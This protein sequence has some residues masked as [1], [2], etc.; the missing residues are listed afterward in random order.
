[1]GDLHRAGGVPAVMKELGD[2][3]DTSVL[4]VSG[5]TLGDTIAGVEVVD[6]LVIR[7]ISDP[8]HKK[9]GIAVLRGSL[10]PDSCVAKVSA[11]SPKMMMFEGRA[12][13]FEREED[14]VDAIHRGVVGPG[15]AVIIRYEG[16]K[17]GPG[18]REMLTATSAIVGHGLEESVALIT[19]GRFSGATRGPCIG[20]ISPEASAGGPIALVEDGD[21]ILIDI[22]ERRIE[23]D[24]PK[25]EMRRRKGAWRPPEP[26]VRHGYLARYAS[27][28]SS[29]DRGAILEG[30][31]E[32]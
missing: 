31:S 23:L 18:M 6:H 13:V 28:V 2:R 19:D 15:D 26:R 27:M 11:M 4:T 21:R 9:G 16:P 32:K 29:A 22:P 20:H 12:V 7:P 8:V 1:M 25:V 17:G 24:V 30:P 10:A 5:K 3:I 14:A